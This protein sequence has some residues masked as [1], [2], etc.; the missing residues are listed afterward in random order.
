M[1]VTQAFEK[2]LE[3]EGVGYKVDIQGK[4]LVLNI[5]FSH[6]VKISIPDT[7]KVKTE[8]NT[9]IVNGISSQEVGQFAAKVRS[10]R[11]PNAYKGN[12]IRY[13]DEIIKKKAGKKIAGATS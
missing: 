3:V 10:K 12:G 9:I 2:K 5:G 7:L 4:E 6:Q 11:P 13:S 8:K 1:G